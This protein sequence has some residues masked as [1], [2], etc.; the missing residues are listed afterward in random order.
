M[1]AGQM[2]QLAA[3]VLRRPDRRRSS[4]PTAS[5][6]IKDNPEAALPFMALGAIVNAN[7]AGFLPTELD[8]DAELPLRLPPARSRCRTRSGSSAT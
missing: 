1:L 3:V 5:P 8:A 4:S 7:N 6:A 2:R